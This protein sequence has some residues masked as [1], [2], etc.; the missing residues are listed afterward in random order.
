MNSGEI[1]IRPART[2]DWESAMEMVWK[3]FLVFEAPEYDEEGTK[4]FLE[5][6]TGQQLFEM[7]KIGE[8]PVWVALDKE[9]IVGVGS[10]RAKS[11][12]SLLFVDKDYQKRGIGRELVKA[13]QEHAIK[14][15]QV[16][17]TVN[18]SPYG[19][20]FYHKIGFIDAGIKKETDGIIYTPMVLLSRV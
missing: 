5:F 10:L 6:I 15:G 12:I 9:R 1:V 18:A 13:M 8:Y 16:R 4:H 3:T 19:E 14:D 7:F 20:A 11:H 17:I 2:E